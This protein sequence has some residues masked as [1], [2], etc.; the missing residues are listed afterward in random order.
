MDF[1]MMMQLV[2][3]GL[4]LGGSAKIGWEGVGAICWLIVKF[5]FAVTD[6]WNGRNSETDQ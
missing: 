6:R 3:F 2:G 1:D 4:F 5:T